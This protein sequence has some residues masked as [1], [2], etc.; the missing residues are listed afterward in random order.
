MTWKCDR[1]GWCEIDEDFVETDKGEI[2]C[3]GCSATRLVEGE[4]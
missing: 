4:I 2:L 1:C 3:Y